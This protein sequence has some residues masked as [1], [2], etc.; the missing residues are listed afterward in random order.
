[1][2]AFMIQ[3]L[4]VAIVGGG[5]GG[6]TA[7]LTLRRAGFDVHVYEQAPA[8]SEVGAGIQLAPNCTRILR[9]LGLLSAIAEMAV[10]PSAFEFRRWDD[11]RVLSETPL[12]DT[13]EQAFGAPYYHVHRADLIAILVQALPPDRVHLGHRC[14]GVAEKGERV[15]VGF[16]YGSTLEADLV[17]GADGIHSEVRRALLGPEEPRFTGN[18]AYRGLVPVG[19]I[20]HLGLEHKTTSRLGP[21]AH[22]RAGIRWW[23]AS[24]MLWTLRSNGP[25]STAC[26]CRAG[27]LDGL[28]CWA[29]RAIPCCPIWRKAR[30]RPS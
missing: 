1:M 3:Q 15:E 14:V 30:P 23:A 26:H 12:G 10:R 19:R 5:I 29:T 25:C 20:A 18:V 24:S 8:L 6:L 16:A 22:T 7:A 4:S 13:I 2:G 27:A 21:D 17:V 9:R 28:R 11:N